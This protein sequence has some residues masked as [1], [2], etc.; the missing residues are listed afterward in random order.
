MRAIRKVNGFDALATF[1]IDDLAIFACVNHSCDVY[2]V[3]FHVT[4]RA[5][6]GIIVGEDGDGFACRCPIAIGIV[7]H[8]RSQH[9]A[10]H[11]IATKHEWAF[12]CTSGKHGTFGMDAPIALT[13]FECGWHGYVIIHALKAAKNITI[14][15]AENCG[16]RHK[17]D[18]WHRCE[19]GDHCFRKS[20]SAHAVDF[21]TLE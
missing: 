19:F 14:K 20:E 9:D 21:F 17:G 6:R 5:L 2:A 16:A 15:P 12:F 11:I 18:V 8:G 10:G 4:H 13:R 1:D 7:A 3:V